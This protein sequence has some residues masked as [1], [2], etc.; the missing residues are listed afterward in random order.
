MRK[1]MGTV[2]LGGAL[3]LVPATAN[4]QLA[5]GANLSL[6]TD[7][8]LG[9]GARLLVG[10]GEAVRHL[11]GIGSFDYFFPGENVNWWELNANVVLPVAVTSG[12]HPYLGAGLNLTN[13]SVD[14]V[15][16]TPGFT[17][18]GGET[19]VGL[20]LVGGMKLPTSG[21]VPFLEVRTTIGGGSQ[22]VLTAGLLFGSVE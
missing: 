8:D 10:L 12:F 11:E 20:N 18:D 13:T 14:V 7:S 6:G 16:G 9:V 2:L 21:A 4:G 22:V 15:D 19:D 17:D 5:I 1:I 3:W